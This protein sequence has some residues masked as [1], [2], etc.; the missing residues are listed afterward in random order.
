M[1]NQF[2]VRDEIRA[3]YRGTYEGKAEKL[4]PWRNKLSRRL[5]KGGIF[6]MISGPLGMIAAGVMAC[7]SAPFV[8]PVLIGGAALF[9][10]GLMGYKSSNKLYRRIEKAGGELMEADIT[11]LTLV[12]SYVKNVLPEKT[13]AL[14]SDRDAAVKSHDEKLT[15]MAEQSKYLGDSRRAALLILRDGMSLLE[16]QVEA[17]RKEV[18]FFRGEAQALGVEFASAVLR[19]TPAGAVPAAAPVAIPNPPKLPIPSNSN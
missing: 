18:D 3:H 9:G 4:M 2:T 15:E 5:H 13:T 19:P 11:N 8:L 6:S 17:S 1:A 10:L 16:Q 12:K 14:Q 7:F